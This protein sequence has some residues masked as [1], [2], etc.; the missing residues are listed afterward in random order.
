VPDDRKEFPLNHSSQA[1]PSWK[2]RRPATADPVVAIVAVVC[3]LLVAACSATATPEQKR[4]ASHPMRADKL[5]AV[6]K[7]FDTAVRSRVPEEIDEYD[8][9]E[10]VFPKI[11]DAAAEL[12][13]SAIQLSGNPPTRLE[14]PD[15]AR[16]QVLARSLAEAAQQLEDAAARS[17][18]DAV[19]LARAQVG[20]AC[21][22]CHS[23][24][25]KEAPGMPDAFR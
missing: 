9:W 5:Q 11:A 20:R 23:Q 12:K 10:G 19:P 25:R 15:R 3:A 13:A 14:L 16:F 1:R 8:R 2:N 24:F 4:E 21:R 6:M 7:G 17:D 22:D 18:A